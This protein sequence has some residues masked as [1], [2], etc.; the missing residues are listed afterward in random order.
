MTDQ[1]SS[2]RR[3]GPIAGVDVAWPGP[4][5]V[6]GPSRSGTALVRAIVNRHPEIA[7]AGETHYFDDLRV[8]LGARAQQPLDDESRR[9]CEDYFLQLSHRPYGHGGTVAGARLDRA[10]LRQRASELGGTGDAYFAAYCQVSGDREAPRIWGEKTPR[11]IF[12]VDEI[13]A[14]F[15]TAKVICMV[16]DPRSVALSYRDWRNQGGFD[17]D[18]DP[19]HA[20]LLDE[21]SERTRSSYDLLVL[22]LLW[23]AQ[24]QAGLRALTTHGAQQIRLQ[25]YEDLV[26][27]PQPQIDAICEFL[28]VESDRALADVPMLNSSFSRFDTSAG[29]SQEGLDR[30]RQRLSDEEVAVV[31]SA[32]GTLMRRL[33]YQTAEVHVPRRR[34]ARH[35]LRLPRT[36]TRAFAANR[37]RMGRAVPYLARRMRLLLRPS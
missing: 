26:T 23:R 13:I 19:D 25:R 11:H 33:G 10:L 24:A 30:W 4:L 32:C 36:A 28:G 21:E 29:V 18:E 37:S 3:H 20:R 35:W 9:A 1:I 34:V 2:Q 6:V 12:R 22:C 5:I 17:L 31:Q 14:A 27:D 7:I 16:R 15:P 8:R